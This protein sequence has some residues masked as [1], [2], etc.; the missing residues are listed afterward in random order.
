MYI[1]IPMSRFILI[2][3]RQVAHH[4]RNRTQKNVC[5]MSCE[6]VR[7]LVFLWKTTFKTSTLSASKIDTG[8]CVL[9]T[10]SQSHC[11]SVPILPY[12][13]SDIETQPGTWMPVDSPLG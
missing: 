12:F 2:Q 3:P 5:S 8:I 6:L 7:L 9:E 11:Q 1:G 13:T 4:R 10:T